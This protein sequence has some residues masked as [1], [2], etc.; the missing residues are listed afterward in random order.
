[1]NL[2][3]NT[4]TDPSTHNSSFRPQQ[5][6]KQ[7]FLALQSEAKEEHLNLFAEPTT[8]HHRKKRRQSMTNRKR[9]LVAPKESQQIKPR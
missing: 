4:D 3:A 1:M 9:D 7:P 5:V 2:T 8:I 6:S